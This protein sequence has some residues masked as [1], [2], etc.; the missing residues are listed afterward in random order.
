MSDRVTLAVK[1]NGIELADHAMRYELTLAE[2]AGAWIG[3]GVAPGARVEL[4]VSETIAGTTRARSFEMIAPAIAP[5][6][7][8]RSSRG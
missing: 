4:I 5:A 3:G 1:V 2:L 7:R 6:D 8:G